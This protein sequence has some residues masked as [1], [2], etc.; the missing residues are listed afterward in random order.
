MLVNLRNGS[1]VSIPVERYL[2]MSDEEINNLELYYRGCE[3]NDP[4]FGSALTGKGVKDE[5][6]KVD[7]D[8]DVPLED[9]VEDVEEVDE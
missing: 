6:E 5:E 4:F 9:I 2:E 7:G 8:L 3:I 1:T